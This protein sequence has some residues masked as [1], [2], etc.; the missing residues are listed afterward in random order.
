M[1]IM[2]AVV[3]ALL[4]VGLVGCAVAS[5]AWARWDDD[6][7]DTKD[8]NGRGGLDVPPRL[9]PN[10]RVWVIH[11]GYGFALNE[12]EFHVLRIHLVRMKHLE[13]LDIRGLIESGMSIEEIRAR[14]M[15]REGVL[16]YQGYL[17]FGQETYRLVNVSVSENGDLKS[18]IADM[19]DLSNGATVGRI[20]VSLEEKEGFRV[21]VGELTLNSASY[22]V[23]LQVF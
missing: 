6:T 10:P 16:S 11:R 20:S 23:L 13:P 7:K 15:E 18:F 12:S 5:P 17:R 19:L 21:G 2:A 22:R 14:L 4:L 1:K 8:T 3:A 9:G